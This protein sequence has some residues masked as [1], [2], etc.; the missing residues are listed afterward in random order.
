[1]RKKKAEIPSVERVD[2]WK[3]RR[4]M[5]WLS[6]VAGLIFPFLILSVDSKPLGDIATPFYLFVSSV[7]GCYIGF[8]TYDDTRQESK[9]E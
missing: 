5:A 8:A 2:R 9:K 6:I 1:M 7:V 4:R 3:N